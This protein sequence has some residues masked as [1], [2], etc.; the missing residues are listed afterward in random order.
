MQVSF[1]GYGQ[2]VATFVVG[3]NVE[4]GSPVM[5][6]PNG[7]VNGTAA[8]GDFCGICLSKG[9][10]YAAVQLKGYVRQSYTGTLSTGRVDLTGAA[11]GKV[12][13]SGGT[14]KKVAVLVVDTDDTAKI[15]GFIL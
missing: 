8:G 2:Q 15:C 4:A 7:T 6:G 5:I 3:D 10:G 11:G 14:D 1:N 12:K 9:N 13:V